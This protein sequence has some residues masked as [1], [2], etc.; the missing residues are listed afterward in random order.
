MSSS[1]KILILIVWTALC[2]FVFSNAGSNILY[3]AAIIYTIIGTVIV[4]LIKLFS[5]YGKLRKG[6]A[7]SRSFYL[8]MIEFLVFL[9]PVGLAYAGFFG[10]LRFSL[11]EPA[12][13]AYVK[14]V[15]NGKVDLNF[16]FTHPDR[17][18]GLYRISFTDILPDGTV[19]VITSAD[20]VFDS[21]GFAYSYQ[22]PPPRQGEDT[23]EPIE[24][25]WWYWRRSW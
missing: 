23:Y 11:S 1:I 20:G 25:N 21:A 8:L 3:V 7:S 15:K 6:G 24:R 16:E 13:M 22:I 5:L 12:L 10:Y 17:V 9:F 4:W 19:R 2:G 18:V 14:D